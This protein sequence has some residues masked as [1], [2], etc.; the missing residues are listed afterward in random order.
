MPFGDAPEISLH[1]L[2]F[3]CSV[4]VDAFAVMVASGTT[5]INGQLVLQV[6]QATDISDCEK[7]LYINGPSDVAANG[8]GRCTMAEVPVMALYSGVQ[9]SWPLGLVPATRLR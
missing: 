9:G 3:T 8:Y 2:P 7:V 1:W 4:A 5:T 6:A